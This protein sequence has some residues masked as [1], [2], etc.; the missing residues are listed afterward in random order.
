MKNKKDL[1]T[2]QKNSRLG[3]WLPVNHEH[4]ASW[5]INQKNKVASKKEAI[6]L[7][8]VMQK[9]QQLIDNNPIVR[10]YI[11]QMI[12]QVPDWHKTYH[13]DHC[14]NAYLESV[15]EMITL[16]NEVLNQAP[17]FN[18]T[19]LVGCPIN[20]ILD[21]CM[22]TPAGGAAF[23][24]ND[25]NTAFH[26]ILN[27]WCSF[28]NSKDSTK[29]LNDS[30]SGWMC[31]SAK[32]VLHMEDYQY[33]PDAPH[34]GFE[35]WNGFFTR[36]LA[37][38]ARPIAEPTNN[39]VIVSGCDSTVF[40]ISNNVPKYSKFWIKEQ[41]YSLNDMLNNDETTDQFIGGDVYQA[42][43]CAFDYHR[44][45]SPVTGTIKKAYVKR[46]TYYSETLAAGLDIGGPD[47]SQAYIAHI[48]TRAIIFIEADD[49]TIGLMCMIPV[50]MAE[51][52][53]CIIGD[54]IKPGKKVNK[55][56]EVGY[57]QFGGSTHCLV[58]RPGVIKDFTAKESESFKMGQEIAIA[59]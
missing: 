25:V 53:S 37:K 51:I 18:D 8:Q 16:I 9:F 24:N 38:G 54:D 49:P 14:R 35:S 45:H 12:S 30:P 50:G 31:D 47:L 57:F 29:V 6:T 58:F 3:G 40:K 26:E 20:A 46:E 59:N 11:T 7:D 4:L 27:R 48:A 55:G 41:P 43:L 15:D 33:K 13:S 22:D 23:R 28:L 2:N 1:K 52:S 56:D 5:L 42:F 19:A 36:K 32:E 44:W 17:E 34:W 21:W 39:K 10:M